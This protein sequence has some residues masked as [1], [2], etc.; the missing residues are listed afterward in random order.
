MVERLEFSNDEMAGKAAELADVGGLKVLSLFSG[1][2]IQDVCGS[3][4]FAHFGHGDA[5]KTIAACECKAAKQMFIKHIVDA[6][7]S[8]KCIFTWTSSL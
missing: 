6:G 8:E 1:S 7:R 2:E 4:A 3:A 5:Y